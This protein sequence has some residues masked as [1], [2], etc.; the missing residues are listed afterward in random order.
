MR[1]CTTPLGAN[2]R[3]A[4]LKTLNRLESVLARSEWRDARVWEGLMC[5]G[6]GNI[7]SGTMSNLFIR[8]GSAL[9]TPQLDRC[10]VAGVMRRW[11]LETA[12]DLGLRI[13][14]RRVRLK[15]LAGAEEVFLSNAVAGVIT[16]GWIQRG[17]LARGIEAADGGTGNA[18]GRDARERGTGRRD[19]GAGGVKELRL[20]QFD[21]ADRL[22]ERLNLL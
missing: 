20:R 18:S 12:G 10:G 5:D 17:V 14:E 6:D 11:I 2:P 19:T 15:D 8:R 1:F 16:V 3:L 9:V 13:V 4:G 22:R 7:V 21:A